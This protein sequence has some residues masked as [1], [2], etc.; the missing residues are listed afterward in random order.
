M[1]RLRA[2]FLFVVMALVASSATAARANP[3]PVGLPITFGPGSKPDISYDSAGN[4]V[5]VWNAYLP[6]GWCSFCRSA[7]GRRHDRYGAELGETFLV[8]QSPG[9]VERVWAPRVGVAPQGHFIVTWTSDT[10]YETEKPF[11]RAYMADGSPAG[12]EFIASADGHAQGFGDAAALANG[13]FVLVWHYNRGFNEQPQSDVVVRALDAEG[14]PLGDP[15]TVD[16]PGGRHGSP[17]VDAADD[18]SFVVSWWAVERVNEEAASHIVAR[19]FDIDGDPSSTEFEVSSFGANAYPAL[20]V[21]RD[22]SFMLAWENR[23]RDGPR[24]FAR[25][26]DA[27][28]SALGPAVPVAMD[29]ER[30]NT[31]PAVA[32]LSDGGF[33]V[34][35]ESYEGS[36]RNN[37][38]LFARTFADSGEAEGTEFRIETWGGAL[39]PAVAGDPFGGFTVVW[40]GRELTAQRFTRDP[41]C[42]DADGD[43]A[44]TATDALVILHGAVG[45][46][47]CASCVCDTDSSGVT[48]ARDAL[49]VLRA[50]TAEEELSCPVCGL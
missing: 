4:F 30:S 37:G 7:L 15:F 1:R 50:A 3:A 20:G 26:H 16:Q 9:H 45:N 21:G 29:T 11:A 48:T 22:G 5:V 41:H 12:D 14:A 27:D 46:A 47:A 23:D 8:N 34:V 44:T 32:R 31:V 43:R 19:R 33:V 24:V 10:E 40:S 2:S 39:Y 49:R 28:N 6:T 36:Y 25:Q 17:Q 13:S 18:G 35:W 38:G 42:A